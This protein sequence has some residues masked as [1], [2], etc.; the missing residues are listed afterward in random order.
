MKLIANTGDVTITIEIDEAVLA[1]EPSWEK[2]RVQMFELLADLRARHVCYGPAEVSA[3]PAVLL[4]DGMPSNELE[5]VSPTGKRF[6]FRV[7]GDD[8]ERI[9]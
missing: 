4:D 1:D 2:L 8:I 9:G 5:L 3:K 6:R 7:V